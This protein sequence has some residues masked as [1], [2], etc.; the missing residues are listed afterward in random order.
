MIDFNKFFLLLIYFVL[1]FVLSWKVI[2]ND[3]TASYKISS[4]D[5]DFHG[6]PPEKILAYI[7]EL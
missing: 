3:D 7:H 6:N 4:I 1:F 5:M 2:L